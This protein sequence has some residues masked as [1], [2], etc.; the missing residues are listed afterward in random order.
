VVS[1]SR[2]SSIFPELPPLENPL[3][4][5][6]ALAHQPVALTSKLGAL[7]PEFAQPPDLGPKDR[8]EGYGADEHYQKE[9][10]CDVCHQDSLQR[11]RGV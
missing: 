10:G 1:R 4:L 11:P 2:I 5:F 3:L 7:A 9:R 6:V 8:G